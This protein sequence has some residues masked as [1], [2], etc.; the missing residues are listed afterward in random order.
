MEVLANAMM[1]ITLQY[2]NIPN[3][4]LYTLNLQ[5][6]YVNYI[7]IK[8]PSGFYL[9]LQSLLQTLFRVELP[10]SLRSA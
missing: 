1:V 3:Q 10:Y 5:N 2:I 4:Q 6:I 9:N 7:S 8:P